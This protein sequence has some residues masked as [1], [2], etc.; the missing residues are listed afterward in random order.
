MA[1]T[2]RIKRRA[3]GAVGAPASLQNAEL[4][5][6]EVDDTLYY[7]KGTGGAAGSATTV[8][9]I[10]G[11]G[12]YTDRTTDQ[13][14]GGVK[15]FSAS[16]VVPTL[17]ASDSSTKAASTAFVKSQNYITGNQA[18][19]LS[20]DVTGTGTTAI[21]ATLAA[22]G[23]TAGTYNNSATTST[24]LTVDSKGR[25][26][27]T[28]TPVTI[29]PAFSSITGTPTTLSG[30]G[31]T[32]AVASSLL[33]AANGVATL[34]S[35]GKVPASQLPSFV[36]DVLE[37]ANFA[38]LPATGSTGTIYVTL[39]TNKIYRWSGSSYIEIGPTSGNADTA[40]KLSTPRTISAT[41]DAAWT[42]SFDG[43]ANVTAALTLANSGATAG[44]Y[45]NSATAVSPITVDD[46]GRVT[47]IG[48]AV[49][50]TPAW[51]SISGKP[52]TLSGFGI[53]DAQALDADLTAIAALSGA[54]GVLRKTAANT[55]ELDTATFLIDGMTIDGGTF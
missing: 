50:I 54:A 19:T 48:A 25:I 10:A 34:A 37:F 43:S 21:A 5:Y 13:T 29:T 40:L 23:V 45:N 17:A 7:G 20:G 22:S 4:A 11:K 53:S 55:W 35:D 16:P 38:G 27:A 3:S 30:Y 47:G 8:E 31:I 49:T 46:K 24:P 18:I 6:N 1:N 44:T 2:L 9:A 14:V 28:G 52:T 39:D 33:G 42:V 41:G 32:D 51:A 36:D 12:A 26:T 15:T